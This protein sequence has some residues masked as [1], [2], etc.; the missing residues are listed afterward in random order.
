MDGEIVYVLFCLFDQCV[1]EDFLGEF[2]GVFVYFFQC[3]VD[4]YGIDCYG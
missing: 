3:L 2:F 1:M 4:W